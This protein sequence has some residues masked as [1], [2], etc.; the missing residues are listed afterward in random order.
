LTI[1]GSTI[2]K[3]ARIDP[4]G[5][6]VVKHVMIYAN[7]YPYDNYILE[8]FV[9]VRVGS[10]VL[11][12]IRPDSVE[13]IGKQFVI[14][15]RLRN[16]LWNFLMTHHNFGFALN[17]G[18]PINKTGVLGFNISQVDREGVNLPSLPS[19]EFYSVW[20]ISPEPQ[21]WNV[22]Y[23]EGGTC[24]VV[25]GMVGGSIEKINKLPFRGNKN[26]DKKE[27]QNKTKETYLETIKYK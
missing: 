11:Y 1:G 26:E 16:Y 19:I 8:T 3:N 23:Y 9:N 10:Q 14:Y 25:W 15:C 20:T 17:D 24:G 21:K 7:A 12:T 5:I 6:D 18:R 13:L 2:P 22:F 4:N 27:E